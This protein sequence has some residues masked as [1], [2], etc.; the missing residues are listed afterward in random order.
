MAPAATQ[1]AKIQTG[2]ATQRMACLTAGLHR[3]EEGMAVA[4]AEVEGGSGVVCH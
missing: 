2:A 4:E 1:K 3:T